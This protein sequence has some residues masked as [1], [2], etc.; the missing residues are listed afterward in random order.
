MKDWKK[1]TVAPEIT[2]RETLRIIDRTSLQIALLVDAQGRLLGTVTDGDVRRGLLKG[3]DLD[4]PVTEVANTRPI[5]ASMDEDPA[6]LQRLMIERSVRQVPLVDS[7]GRLMG[8]ELL[9]D[10]VARPQRENL[11]VLMAGGLGTRLR[12]LTESCP[13]PLLQV[14]GKPIL[15][16]IMEG[17]AASGFRRFAISVNYKA[18]MIESH[19]GDGSAWGLDI[20]Y[21]REPS[22]LGTAGA[23]TL[24]PEALET[25]ILVMNG[26]LL[27]KLNFAALLDFHAELGAKATICVREYDFEVPFGVVEVEGDRLTALH[28]KPVQ[29]FLVNA[30]IYVLEPAAVARIPRGEPFDMTTLFQRLVEE[31]E[32]PAVFPI[33]EYWLDIGHMGDY[34]RAAG[35]FVKLAGEDCLD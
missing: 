4:S 14:G 24:L 17:L 33:R 34:Q 20:S 30:G 8:L 28:E 7:A 27:T 15:E 31:G 12:P 22:R 19:F 21:L 9:K 3:L 26:D 23:L 16:I 2:I 11:V 29:K 6:S 35:E 5:V 13:K 25:P 18:E 32:R 1:A 10:L